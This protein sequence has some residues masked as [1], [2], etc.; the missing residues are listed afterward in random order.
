MKEDNQSV[1]NYSIENVYFIHLS[2]A[3]IRKLLFIFKQQKYEI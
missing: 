1:C 2:N 3:L